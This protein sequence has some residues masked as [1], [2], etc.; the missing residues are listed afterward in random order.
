M[1]IASKFI[2]AVV[3]LSFAFNLVW[4]YLHLPL[5]TGY[6]QLGS[7]WPLILWATSGDVL[8]TVLITTFVV[9]CSGEVGP[10]Y[11]RHYAALGVGGFVVALLVEYKAMALH[12][13]AYT[14]A[15]PTLFHV[16]LSPLLQLTTLVPLS[17]FLAQRWARS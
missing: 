4:E 10:W 8:Y 9:L 15:M 17:V 1:R 6:E 14:T 12:T 2:A 16:G 11:I 13:W 3:A 7:G 5:Y